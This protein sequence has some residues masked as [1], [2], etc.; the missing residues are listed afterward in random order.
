MWSFSKQS[1]F[2]VGEGTG[3]VV[4]RCQVGVWAYEGGEGARGQIFGDI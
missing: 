3:R 1:V 4:L 2:E